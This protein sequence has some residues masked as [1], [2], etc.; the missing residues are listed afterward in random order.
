V[1][2]PDAAVRQVE[3]GVDVAVALARRDAYLADGERITAEARARAT[4]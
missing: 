2:A 4:R 1:R 3:P